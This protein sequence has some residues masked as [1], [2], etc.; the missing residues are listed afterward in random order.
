M[1]ALVACDLD[2]VVWRIACDCTGWGPTV[3]GVELL[4]AP[5]EYLLP[6]DHPNLQAVDIDVNKT[7]VGKV[8]IMIGWARDEGGG[9]AGAIPGRNGTT[10]DLSDQGFG[11]WAQL[12]WDLT[13]AEVLTDSGMA[14]TH[15]CTPFICN[16]PGFIDRE[17]DIIRSR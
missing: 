13:F 11:L 16:K 12:K 1:I 5:Q 3:D 10:R 15:R 7:S 17:T 8:P 14:T 6:P 2:L 4:A 9:F